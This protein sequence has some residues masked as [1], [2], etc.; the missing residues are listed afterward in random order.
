MNGNA[1]GEA[2]W[3]GKPSPDGR[4]RGARRASSWKGP[5]PSRSR[6]WETPGA[7][8]S[9]VL[10]N[11]FSVSYPRRLSAAAGVFEGTVSEGSGGGSRRSRGLAAGSTVRGHDRRGPPSGSPDAAPGRERSRPSGSRRATATSPFPRSPPFAPTCGDPRPRTSAPP[12][13]AR[14]TS[15]S[16]PGS[17]SPSPSPSSISGRAR[18]C[19]PEAVALEDVYDEFGFGEEGPAAVKA[20]LSYAYHGWQRPSPRYVLLLGDA[21]Y[22]PKD[23]TKTGTKD[24]LPTPLARTSFL[25]TAS[26]PELRPGERRRPPARLRPRPP[27]RG[28]PRRGPGDDRQDP[29]LRGSAPRPLRAGRPRRRQR[30]PG[31]PLRGE[32]RRDRGPSCPAVTVE[33]LYLRDLAARVWTPAP[34]SGTPSTTA[35]PS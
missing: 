30:R 25:W 9:M 28:E 14:T 21:T 17:S 29:R 16:H 34:P 35:P 13:T 1:V 7:A 6:T 12:R 8:Y 19:T 26:D 2:S 27:S 11:R 32:R 20:F 31:R 5:T 15:S 18:A 24:R 23:F 22:D 3:D 33:K 10:L 4:G